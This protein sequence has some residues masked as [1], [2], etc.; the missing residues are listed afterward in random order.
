[1]LP[2]LQ[3][4][5][6]TRKVCKQQCSRS[7]NK[8]NVCARV[9]LEEVVY[10]NQNVHIVLSNHYSTYYTDLEKEVN[11]LLIVFFNRWGNLDRH[12]QS[13]VYQSHIGEHL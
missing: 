11:T 1:M 9:C 7:N 5:T 2:F 12:H 8:R 13:M 3:Q 6:F 10:V 4:L